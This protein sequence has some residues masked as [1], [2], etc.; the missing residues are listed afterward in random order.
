MPIFCIRFCKN[1]CKVG[2]LAAVA[3]CPCDA[4]NEFTRFWKLEFR[5][6]IALEPVVLLLLELL[7]E[8]LL[9]PDVEVWLL[10]VNC[11]SRF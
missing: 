3:L 5:L 9:V 2:A 1:V 10:A 8:L 4:S 11:W 6:L 7:L